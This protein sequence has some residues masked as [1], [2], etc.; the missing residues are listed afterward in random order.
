MFNTQKTSKWNMNGLWKFIN[1]T[2]NVKKKSAQ[3]LNDSVYH[4]WLV[5]T[6]NPLF[7]SIF[8]L[9]YKM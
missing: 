5:Y 3:L 4:Y 8:R 6:V 7:L 1:S 2:L 9:G